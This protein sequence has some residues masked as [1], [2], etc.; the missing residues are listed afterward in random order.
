LIL[1]ACPALSWALAGGGEL[2][3]DAYS[4]QVPPERGWRVARTGADYVAYS[5]TL[6]RSHTWMLTAAAFPL[7]APV[8]D[9]RALLAQAQA[10]FLSDSA[11]ERFHIVD[12]K[13]SLETLRGATCARL[14]YKAED[15]L[16]G[17]ESPVYIIEVTQV[18]CVHPRAPRLEIVVSYHARYLP[19]E[20]AAA[21]APFGE[22]FIRGVRFW[23][24]VGETTT[25]ANSR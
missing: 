12:S 11:P 20:S 14:F 25:A 19:G 7:A 5:A 3:F 15:R 18:T 17:G 21:L 8:A 4:I 13:A 24:P 9:G 23:R 10:D 1:A 6:T 22:R 16:A 2:N